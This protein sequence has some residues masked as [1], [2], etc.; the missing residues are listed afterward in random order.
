MFLSGHGPNYFYTT[1]GPR[2]SLLMEVGPPDSQVTARHT[3]FK[4]DTH[5]QGIIE[6]EKKF[7]IPFDSTRMSVVDEKK[8][9]MHQR[10]HS[11]EIAL[12]QTLE[13]GWWFPCINSQ[14]LRLRM[15]QET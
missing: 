5:I 9:K 4:F 15:A 6:V 11:R 13:V 10:E 7:V 8:G 2:H 12:V 3:W 14:S 1:A